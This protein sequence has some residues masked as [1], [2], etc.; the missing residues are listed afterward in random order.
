M[1]D[2]SRI[3]QLRDKVCVVGVGETD[4]AEDW[5]M[6]RAGKVLHDQYGLAAIAFTRALRDS[7][8][9]KRDIDGVIIGGPM[10]P[11]RTCEI[12]GLDPRWT[13]SGGAPKAIL[14]AVLAVNAG[15]VSTVALIYGNNQRTGGTQYGGPKAMGGD[16]IL[17][18]VYY[19]P[20]GLTSQGALYAMLLQRYR[21]LHG[22]TEEQL[23]HVAVSQRKFATMNPNAVMQQ[24]I[25]IEDYLKGP[26]IT[27]PLH[28]HDYCLINDG[29]VSLILTREDL[30][31]DR[32]KRP[33]YISGIG[34][35]EMNIGATSLRPRMVDFYHPAH[36]LVKE[37][38]YPAAGI[39]QKDIDSVQIYDSF[40]VHVPLA[41][42]GFG[43]CP[44]GE[45]G[46]FVASGAIG[47]GGKLPVNTSGGMLSESYM[48]GWNHQ[49]ETVRQLRGEAGDRQVANG[50][51]VQWISDV[52]GKCFSII[53]R[54]E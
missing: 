5:K 47:P 18:Y 45:G 11:E 6:N 49:V 46:A 35:A 4:Y 12:L 36:Q 17:S 26:Y 34:S 39:E 25:T 9:N 10:A 8:L 51:H 22:I 14:D 20:W 28:L 13:S 2:L 52:A 54:K 21:H 16:N 15:L 7:G 43:F 29:G 48:Q 41:L 44:K 32:P 38:V 33:V 30:A 42:E 3:K 37:Q 31:K 1:A 27:E 53:Y 23:G 50:R 24:P 40:S 19:A